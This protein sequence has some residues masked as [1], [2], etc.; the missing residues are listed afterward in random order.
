MARYF[1][2][3]ALCSQAIAAGALVFAAGALPACS[4]PEGTAS[5]TSSGSDSKVGDATS[6][7]SQSDGGSDSKV[8]TGDTASG[9]SV[10]TPRPLRFEENLFGIW[11]SSPSDMWI[12]GQGGRLLYWNGKVLLPRDS[13]TTADLYGVGGT[14]PS[15]VWFVGSKAKALHWNGATV[16]DQSPP[17]GDLTLR[18]VGAAAGGATVLVAG[19]AG[20]V[21]RFQEGGWKPENTKSSFNLRSIAVSSSGNAWAVGDQGVGIKLSGGSWTSQNLPKANVT[22]R[23]IALSPAGR[24]YA[25]GD[26]GYLAATTAGTWEATLA[27]DTQG[28]D[29]YGLWGVS[30]SEAWAIGQKGVLLHLVGKKWQLDDIAGTYM[31]DATLRAL[32]GHTGDDLPPAGFAVGDAGSGI[33]FDPATSTWQDFRAETTA[34]L[35]QVV[36]MADGS[37]YACGTG[38]AVLKAADRNAPF[39]D[40][41]APVTAADLWDCAVS[42]STLWVGGEA[43]LAAMRGSRP[44]TPRRFSRPN[45]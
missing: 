8:D 33:R 22:L 18:A 37:L 14:G 1:G 43:G 17:L 36:A 27:N 39:Y 21:Y 26:T 42:G 10:L 4:S 12:V 25:C 45:V 44:P 41:A 5:D 32:W 13:G 35:R 6:E 15:D 2:R 19:D 40:L 30:D 20:T 16:A 34:D 24:W 29:A 38:G 7:V 31:K 3:R 9:N 11:G 28:R 23:A